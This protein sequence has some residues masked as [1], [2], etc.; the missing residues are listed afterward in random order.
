MTSGAPRPL[1]ELLESLETAGLP[2]GGVD[3]LSFTLPSSGEGAPR[4]IAQP[5]GA[6][7]AAKPVP[8][9]VVATI[10]THLLRS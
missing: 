3:A 5:C 6:G 7:G 9:A 2:A 4:I 1:E 10:E 8:P